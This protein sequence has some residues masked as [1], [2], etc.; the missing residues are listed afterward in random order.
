MFK[1]INK[2]ICV[3]LLILAIGAVGNSNF[4]TAGILAAYPVFVLM[5]SLID[6]TRKHGLA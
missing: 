3:T 6:S 5:V 1:S 2:L 4:I